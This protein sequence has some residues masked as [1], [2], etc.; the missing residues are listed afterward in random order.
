MPRNDIFPLTTLQHHS[1]QY[2]LQGLAENQPSSSNQSSLSLPF[3]RWFKF[4]EAFA[5][6]LV[7]DCLRALNYRPTSCLDAFGGCGTTALTAQFLGIK[8]TLFEVNPFIADLAEAKLCA[9]DHLALE[10]SFSE[11]RRNARSA[12]LDDPIKF[13]GEAP[14][15][16]CQTRNTRRWLFSRSTL[17]RILAYRQSI[18]LLNDPPSKRLLKVLLG[19]CLVSLS[20]VVVNGKG[21]KYR[22]GWEHRQSN[23][24]DVDRLFGDAFRMAVSDT[25]V[26]SHRAT[27]KYDIYRGSALSLINR[28]DPIDVAIFSPPYPNSFDYTDIYNIELWTLGYLRAK[29][30]DRALRVSTLRSHVQVELEQR[31]TAPDSKALTTLVAKLKRAR[32]KLWDPRIPEMVNGYFTDLSTLLDGLKAKLRPG[33]ETFIIVGDSSYSGIVVNVGLILA[34]TAASHGYQV[35]SSTLLRRMRKS[36]QQG[37]DFRLGEHVIRLRSPKRGFI[38]SCRSQVS[39]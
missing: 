15:T 19:A 28:I 25:R 33:G 20:N 36:A 26:Y 4:K 12:R 16:F 24:E 2:W 37:G 32:S 13:L 29:A 7:I 30:E 23:P 8:P 17:A 5:P 21:R 6:S 31:G 27:T 11:V 9:Y 39:S 34:E 14:R 38:P 3:Q 35:V 18:E 10:T 22:S 1:L